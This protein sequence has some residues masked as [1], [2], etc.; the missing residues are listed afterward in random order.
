MAPFTRIFLGLFFAGD[1]LSPRLGERANPLLFPP[2]SVVGDAAAA[3]KEMGTG[4]EP[5]CLVGDKRAVEDFFLE[6]DNA[7]EEEEETEEEDEEEDD[8]DEEE[9]AGVELGA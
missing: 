4:E 6:G 2:A 8:K 1:G 7:T 5:R 9:A 3:A